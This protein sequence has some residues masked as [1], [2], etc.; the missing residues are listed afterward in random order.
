MSKNKLLR[1]SK[2]TE[3]AN[4]IEL[5]NFKIGDYS[6]V[7]G[8]WNRDVFGNNNPI[9]LEL[10][11]GKGDYLLALAQIYPQRNFI[12]I[13]I[14]GDRLWKGA[15]F[16]HDHHLN[17]VRF[18]RAFI[19]HIENY[20]ASG[21]VSEIWITFPDPYPSTT[22]EKKRLTSPYFLEKYRML[23]KPGDPIHIKT[24]SL[25]LFNYTRET[26][27]SE[28]V[29]MLEHTNDV[30]K[31]ENINDILNIKTYYERKHLAAGKAI[32]YLKFCF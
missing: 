30:Y 17:N 23:V 5:S 28:E 8:N 26:L 27:L 1:Y 24:D 16:A 11:C 9:T 21:E 10:A 15:Q 31:T 18:L 7:R 3:L 12:G 13:D 22:K 4:V 32:K 14:K 25:G 29:Q 19:D 6:E 2:I 20:F